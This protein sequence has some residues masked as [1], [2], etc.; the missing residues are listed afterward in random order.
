MASWLRAIDNG[1]ARTK[2]E[3][4]SR[5]RGAPAPNPRLTLA[6]LIG[7]PDDRV[8]SCIVLKPMRTGNVRFAAKTNGDAMK[9]FLY[10]WPA[11]S[12]MAR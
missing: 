5:P 10:Y 12:P 2:S 7:N 4:G 8:V 6:L 1:G 11:S 3:A 9:E